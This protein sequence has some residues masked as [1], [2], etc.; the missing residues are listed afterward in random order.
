MKT[1]R[2][3]GL[4]LALL[5]FAIVASGT[6]SAAT[7]LEFTAGP[8]S[9]IQD[10][11]YP[12]PIEV[13]AVDEDGE[14]D[15][16][17]SGEVTLSLLGDGVLSG[18]LV[19][20]AVD[21]IAVFDDFVVTGANRMVQFVV[22]ADGLSEA[23]TDELW[24]SPHPV[25]LPDG[26]ATWND[27]A[28]WTSPTIPNGIGT[29]VRLL[30]PVAGNR[31][32]ELTAPVVVSGMSIDLDGSP[33]RNR[34]CSG[35]SDATLT[36]ESDWETGWPDWP[37]WTTVYVSGVGNGYVEFE[38]AAGVVLAKNLELIVGSIEGD[39]VYGALRL[40]ESWSGPGGL[41]KGG[42]GMVSLTGGDKDFTGAVTIYEGVLA[43]TEA[44]TPGGSS[45][46]SVWS[47]GQ[48]RL[49]S[50][51]SESN[52]VRSYSFG[53]DIVLRGA[54]RSGMLEGAGMGVLGALRYDPG[55]QD[56][57]AV[58][59][60]TISMDQDA[61]VH[62]DG[63]RNTLD[64]SGA[65]S[66]GFSKSGGGVLRLSGS[67]GGSP[68]V[69]V[70]N[71][72]LHLHHTAGNPRVWLAE[73][74][75]V[76]GIGAVMEVVPAGEGVGGIMEV[77][78]DTEFPVGKVDVNTLRVSSEGV[79]KLDSVVTEPLSV[80]H[81][82]FFV[83]DAQPKAFYR[84]GVASSQSYDLAALLSDAELLIYVRDE[85][86]EVEFD[87]HSYSLWM[88]DAPVL[89]TAE[90]GLQSNGSSETGTVLEVR[91]HEPEFE[92]LEDWTVYH[93]TPGQVADPSVSAMESSALQD[94][95]ANLLKYALG[96][97]PWQRVGTNQLYQEMTPEG[98]L[99][100]RFHYDPNKTDI[101]YLV[102]GSYDLTDWN[103]VYFDSRIDAPPEI[104]EP[105][106]VDFR[107]PIN[108]A[109]QMFIR[110]RIIRDSSIPEP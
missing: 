2:W 13:W 59:T 25:F 89:E 48:L 77:Y 103:A 30:A 31:D 17:F 106:I 67:V 39:P 38:V 96:L 33:W 78:R 55:S 42:R 65:I 79:L 60:N 64:L 26:S 101:V 93:F 45:G 12:G 95:Y 5:I 58:V 44:A 62:V 51:S 74:A 83:E 7:G 40:R 90:Y 10:G 41:D 75:V 56:N 70:E 92:D 52:P 16:D 29:N 24:L 72:Q 9:A 3:A 99:L 68:T 110:L 80:D 21:G 14:L 81:L 27:A 18:T 91:F 34:I 20:A 97:T 87:G 54:G 49:T 76:A 19:V 105:E 47:G 57:S 98:E 43:V 63:S 94:G 88:G 85:S 86:G 82:E 28:N 37:A 32:I 84:T 100:L 4:A 69:T 15:A 73:G 35:A 46:V 104:T 109:P 6:L 61:S 22:T 36:F 50:A 1:S 8:V 102:E 66:G 11:V 53:G 23:L 107:V 71:G 108:G